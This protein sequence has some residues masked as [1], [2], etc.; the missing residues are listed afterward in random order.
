M[1]HTHHNSRILG[2]LTLAADDDGLIIVNWKKSLDASDKKLLA[3]SRLV[4]LD[5]LQKDHSY[6]KA[7]KIL[8]LAVRELEAYGRQELRRFT[9]PLKP[10]GTEFQKTVWSQLLKIPYGKT[11]SYKELAEK[12]GNPQAYRAVANANGKN[13]LCIIVPCHR[14]IASDQSLGG[15]SGGVDIKKALLTLESGNF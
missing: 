14:V 4:S 2:I 7:A 15:Y 13:P 9:V 1:L 3:H 12:T 10:Q 6:S 8:S 5:D 11:I